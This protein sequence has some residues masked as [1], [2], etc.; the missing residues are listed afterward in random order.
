MRRRLRNSRHTRRIAATRAGR[1]LPVPMIRLVRDAMTR[2]RLVLTR[3][4][5]RVG[6]GEETFLVIL[7]SA[8]VLST[9]ARAVGFHE[10]IEE[11]RYL[12]CVRLGH[13]FAL[14]V[15]DRWMIAV[16]PA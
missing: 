13:R 16:L 15:G 12:C 5:A 3:L 1:Y 6:L 9:A 8:I 10:L 2:L 4:L 7:A 14:Y 11:V